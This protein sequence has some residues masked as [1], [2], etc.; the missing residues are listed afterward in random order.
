MKEEI[1]HDHNPDGGAFVLTQDG[2]RV[3]E[4]TYRRVSAAVV[5][6][7]HTFVDPS[8]RGQG[9]ARRLLDAAVSWAR[10]SNTK[11]SGSCSYVVAQFARDKSL[12]DVIA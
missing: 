6:I 7:D 2:K 8:L 4:M 5:D 10:G 11:L 3:A 12:R 1:S 9:V